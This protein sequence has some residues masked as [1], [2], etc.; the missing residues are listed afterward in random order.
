VCSSDLGALYKGIIV[1]AVLSAILLYPVTEWVIGT[2]ASLD[3]L[4]FDRGLPFSNYSPPLAR[5]RIA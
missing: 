2:D 4:F 1:C 5:R 3:W